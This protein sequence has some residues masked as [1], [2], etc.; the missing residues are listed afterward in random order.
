MMTKYEVRAL[1]GYLSGSRSVWVDAIDV[2]HAAQLGCE[3]LEADGYWRDVALPDAFTCDVRDALDE[4]A[5]YH[6]VVVVVESRRAFR[7]VL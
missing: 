3:K 1:G 2:H 7:A 5:P 4:T 6:S